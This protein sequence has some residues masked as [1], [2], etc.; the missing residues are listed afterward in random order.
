[1]ELTRVGDAASAVADLT[2]ELREDGA[3]DLAWL[4]AA[5][6]LQNPGRAFTDNETKLLRSIGRVL[7]TRY[8]LVLDAALAARRIQLVRGLPEDR[9]VSAYLDPAPYRRGD[10]TIDRVAEAIE[11][12]RISSSSTYENN[13]INTGVLLFGGQPDPC[14][15]PPPQP[16]GALPYA[17]ALT[18]TRTFYRLSDGM[19]TVALVDAAGLMVELVDI[20][21][22]AAP[23][24]D[25]SLPVPCAERFVSHCRATLC[26]G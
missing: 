14:H 18:T 12:L 20:E 25:M 16:E 2:I 21:E 15:I 24:A 1:A 9:F 22:W 5:Y 26:G 17:Q 10:V 19:R 6:R 4:G 11:V 23:Y 13:R 7:A 3:I 8:R